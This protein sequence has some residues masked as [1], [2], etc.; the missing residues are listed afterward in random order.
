MDS[1]VE[2]NGA[3][4][5]D[6]LVSLTSGEAITV[7]KGTEDM[8]GFVA[9]KR[10]SERFNPNTPAKALALMMEVMSPKVQ[11][12]PNRIPQA[13]DEWDLKVL[14]LEKEFDEKPSER[15]KTA[16]MLSMV[17]GDMQD[18]MY[19]QAANM[20]NYADARAR[21]KG[22]VQNRIVRGFAM[23]MEIGRVGGSKDQE[24]EDN[25]INYMNKGGKSKGKEKGACHNCGQPGHYARECPKGKEKGRGF[26][27]ACY[28]CG[29][30][31][32]SAKNCTW[33]TKGGKAKGISP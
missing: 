30:Y 5:F 6:L 1:E 21:L 25:G 14:S 18:M 24:N 4:L 31:C 33:T 3:E 9:R 32:H 28:T 13:I 10:L 15:M 16:F 11:I 22:I 26:Q 19:Q 20:K 17:P 27:G 8:N 12:D 2:S 29:E 23:P 7:V